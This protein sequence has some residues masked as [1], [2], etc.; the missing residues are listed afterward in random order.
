MMVFVQCRILA[1]IAPFFVSRKPAAAEV[2]SAGLQPH[3]KFA[4]AACQ[5]ARR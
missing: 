1:A 2:P 3:G 4:G 5:D